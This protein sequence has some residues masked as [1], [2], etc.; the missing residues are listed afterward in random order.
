MKETLCDAAKEA[1]WSTKGGCVRH[2]ETWWWN[3]EVNHVI[4][5]KRKAWKLWKS[6]GSK[7]VYLQAKSAVYIAKR[8]A[9]TEKF[10]SIN[11]NRDK[12]RIFKLAKKLKRDNA[13]IVGEK[14]VRNDEGLLALTVDEK[15]E[16]WQSHYDKLL[17]EEFPWNA[18]SLSDD[19]PMQGP[20]IYITADMVRK[21]M[22]KMKCGKSSGPSGI[23]IEMMR[24]AG[25]FLN[26]LTTLLNRIVYEGTVPSDWNLSFIINLFKGKG[27]ALSR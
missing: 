21:A 22:S 9:Q 25:S 26:E 15:L 14:C 16:A 13:D 1:C 4:C 5:E 19:P 20:V 10:G 11:N 6:G 8:D 23:I 17:N 7:E 27:D 18:D 2:N 24:A 3:D 12:N